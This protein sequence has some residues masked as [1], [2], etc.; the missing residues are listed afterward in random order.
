QGRLNAV[1]PEGLKILESEEVDAKLPS[2]STMIEATRYRITVANTDSHE[3]L[4]QCVQFLAQESYII[5]RTKKGQTKA[6][7]LRG[8]TVSLS[9]EGQTVELVAKRGKPVEFARAITADEALQG[10]DIQVEKLEVIFA[11]P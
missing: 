2:L 5:Q 11:A 4:K 10:D 1:L 9:A 8:E 6:V 3:L 7:D